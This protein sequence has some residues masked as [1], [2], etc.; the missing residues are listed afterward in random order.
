MNGEVK[1]LTKLAYEGMIANPKFDLA[2]HYRRRLFA[3]FGPRVNYTEG[4]KF[5]QPHIARINLSIMVANK[6]LPIWFE[7]FSDDDLPV[8]AINHIHTYLRGDVTKEDYLNVYNRL[9]KH[10]EMM[11]CE[12]E[13][14]QLQIASGFAAL[15]AMMVAIYDENFGSEEDNLGVDEQTIDPDELDTTFYAATSYSNGTIWDEDSNSDKR[16]DFW[17]WYLNNAIPSIAE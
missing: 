7:S 3:A 17:T 8:Q 4:E 15:S 9:K 6:V 12:M 11:E 13:S 5:T 1:K 2:L 10:F 14:K 16:K